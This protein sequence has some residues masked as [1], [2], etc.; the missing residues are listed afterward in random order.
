MT[1]TEVSK[2]TAYLRKVYGSRTLAVR[3]RPKS[4]MVADLCQGD[5]VIGTVTVDDEDGDRS[6][7]LAYEIKEKPQPLSV[8]E[9]LRLQAVLRETLGAKTLVVRARAKIKDSAEVF[10]GDESYAILS[11]DKASYQ[12]QMAILDIDL[13]DEAE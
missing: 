6:Y 4:A 5:Q 7:Q 3:P 1:P 12:F 10:V 13:E 2:L 9:L 8:T 11:A